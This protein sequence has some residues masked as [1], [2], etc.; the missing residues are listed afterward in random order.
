MKRYRKQVPDDGKEL[1]RSS[2]PNIWCADRT[3]NRVTLLRAL[4]QEFVFGNSLS[5]LYVNLLA[6]TIIDQ[7]P[8]LFEDCKKGKMSKAEYYLQQCGTHKYVPG[9]HMPKVRTE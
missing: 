6:R 3:V 5:K 2:E 8:E 9:R 4:V 1:L 7:E